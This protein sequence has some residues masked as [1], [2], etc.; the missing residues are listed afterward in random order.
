MVTTNLWTALLNLR[1][2]D[3]PCTLWV[4]AVC[5][6]QA[7]VLERNHQVSV[8]GKIYR[9]ATRTIVWL[10][11]NYPP[12][13]K[14][15]Y[16]MVDELAAEAISRQHTY[17]GIDQYST[18]L[19]LLELKLVESPLFDRFRDDFSVIHLAG[20][21]WWYRAWT[22][23][24][25]LLASQAV[26][27]AGTFTMDWDRFSAG[28]NY[29]LAIGI[30]NPVLLGI[31]V[32]PIVI[33]YLSM[34]ALRKQRQRPPPPL[35]SQVS[36]TTPAHVLLELLIKCRFRQAS[37]P[38]D[39]V[40][41]LLGLKDVDPNSLDSA[42]GIEPDYGLSTSEVYRH[43]A[44]QLLLQS[45]DLDILGA[46]IPTTN[47]ELPSWVPDWSTTASGPRPLMHDAQGRPRRTHASRGATAAPRF[48][49][50]GSVLVVT[51]HEVTTITHLSPVLHRLYNGEFKLIKRG[52]TL[53]ERLS[54]LGQFFVS[55][56]GLYWELSSVVPH[57]ATFWDWEAFAREFPVPQSQDKLSPST[58][59]EPPVGEGG[60]DPLAVYWQTL[61]TGTLAPG[62][63]YATARLFY[64]WRASLQPIFRLH[65]W[66]VDSL[67]RPLAF[68]GYLKRTWRE[69]SQFARLLEPVYERRLGRGEDGFLSLLPGEAEV[70]DR[71]VLVEGGRVPLLLR[72]DR[73]GGERLYR[74][75]GEA[76]MHGIMDGE[77][78]QEG[79]CVEMK[80][81]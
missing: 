49:H 35:S 18:P 30:W 66:R 34:H 38:R 13:T 43:A 67:F 53:L 78:F 24:E 44:Q 81:A 39:K 33:P 71:L 4:D 19:S 7:N 23:Q 74:L 9:N 17:T 37:D 61:C 77:R 15:A 76:Y 14:K 12:Y 29:G 10:G 16:A 2:P 26:V 55:L 79:K 68:V 54:S 60:Y 63:R 80:I 75:V 8:M 50:N 21:R 42:L 73:V 3:Q 70:G 28:I 6:D 41:A 47:Q 20:A 11:D 27:M 22:V 72:R 65:Q 1:K 40:Y 59:P 46:C 56:V 36:A 45:D 64:S 62:G 25:V 48:L 5:I 58:D 32:D 52:D 51:G 69:Y 57:L 31:I